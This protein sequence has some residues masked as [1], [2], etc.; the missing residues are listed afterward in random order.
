[1]I[2]YILRRLLGMIPLMIGITLISF[3]VIQLAPGG[4]FGMATDLN[5]KI[6]AEA[7]ERM[8]AAYHLDEPLYTQYWLWLKDIAQLNFGTSFNPD[9]LPVLEKISTHLPVTLWMN[10]IGLILVFI[11]AI[12]IGIA[13]A[14][15]QNS[16]FDRAMTVAVFIGFAIPGFWL[17]LLGMLYFGVEWELLP[18]SGISSYGSEAWPFW[19]R[20]L[21]WGHHLILPLTIGLIGSVAGLTRYMRSSMLDVI[22]QDYIT[23]ARAKGLPEHL[24]IY[25]HG[26]RNALMPVVTILGLSIPGLIG[27]SVITESLFSINGMGKLFYDGVMQRDYPLIMGILTIGA[28]LTLLGNFLA[29]LAYALVDPRVRVGKQQ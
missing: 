13:S 17:G 10:I 27:G 11:V 3:L 22:R 6:S 1:M 14:R 4:P 16:G 8:R 25:R 23:T 20:L 26:L 9:G 2:I 7:I 5:P 24:V 19:Q 28:F 21:D 18:I 15:Y 12:P 29:D